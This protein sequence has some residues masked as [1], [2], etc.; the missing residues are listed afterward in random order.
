MRDILPHISYLP[1]PISH[2]QSPQRVRGWIPH[3]KFAKSA[4]GAG[5]DSTQSRKG[6]ELAKVGSASRDH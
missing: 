6:A 2:L 3:A 1:S 4:K 5:L